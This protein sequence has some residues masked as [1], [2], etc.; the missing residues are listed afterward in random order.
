V[1]GERGERYA[2]ADVPGSSLPS[3]QSQKS[4][5]TAEKGIWIAGCEM[6]VNVVVSL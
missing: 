2:Q 5:L 3:G 4:S 1:S 6:Q